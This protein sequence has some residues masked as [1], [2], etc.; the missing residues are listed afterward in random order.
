MTDQKEFVALPRNPYVAL[1]RAT[2][3]LYVRERKVID[4]PEDLPDEL[5]NRRAGAFVTLHKGGDLR[6]C[7]G[8]ITPTRTTLADEIIGNAILAATEDPRFYPVR[9]EELSELDISVDV[10]GEAE[11]VD[12][13][14]DL[15]PVRYGVIVTRGYRGR[16]AEWPLRVEPDS[17]AHAAGDEAVLLAARTR[18]P[19]MAGPDRV[20]AL[21]RLA[22]QQ[23]LGGLFAGLSPRTAGFNSIDIGQMSEGSL[24]ITDVLMFIGGGSAGTA[25]GIKVATFAVLGYVILSEIRGEPSVHAMGRRL[26]QDVQRQAIT[27]VL[28][29]VGAVMAATFALLFLTDFN[30]DQVL[31][32]SVSAFATVGLSTGITADIPDAGQLIL[33]VLMLLGRLGPITLASALAVRDRARRFELPEE[34]P[35]VG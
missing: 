12:S 32:E 13:F 20:A 18:C 10:L 1:A 23:T 5:M 6:G 17:D 9:K 3:D 29:A 4:V 33:I 27:V 21:E 30:L 19:V 2:I 31:F 28:L 25:G 22:A 34:R 14:D 8:T 16:A 35:I 24:L 15:D 7:I 26:G 11:E